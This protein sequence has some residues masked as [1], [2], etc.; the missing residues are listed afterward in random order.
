V[1]PQATHGPP[2][3]FAATSPEMYLHGTV[4]E[5]VPLKQFARLFFAPQPN[6]SRFHAPMKFL[7]CLKFRHHQT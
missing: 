1:N 7:I 3:A 2:P 4:M 5:T 6:F